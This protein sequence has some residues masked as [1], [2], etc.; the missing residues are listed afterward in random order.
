VKVDSI[1]VSFLKLNRVRKEDPVI[2]PM[3]IP[4][5]DTRFSFFRRRY[6]VS[7]QVPQ[8]IEWVPGIKLLLEMPT[9]EIRLESFSS[10]FFV[11]KW[12]VENTDEKN[13]EGIGI[14]ENLHISEQFFS[15]R[16][17]LSLRI[18]NAITFPCIPFDRGSIFLER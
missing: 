12:N 2:L 15:S 11:E 18:T 13:I 10:Q 9:D 6:R 14:V 7:P 3:S 4:D 17:R 1:Y 8:Y 16:I 5:N